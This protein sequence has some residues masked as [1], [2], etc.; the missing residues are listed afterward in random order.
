MI[1]YRWEWDPLGNDPRF[2]KLITQSHPRSFQSA[3]LYTYFSILRY[4]QHIELNSAR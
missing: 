4:V 1:E 3:K 2:P